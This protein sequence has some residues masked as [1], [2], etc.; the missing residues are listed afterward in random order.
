MGRDLAPAAALPH[1]LLAIINI[2][3]ERQPGQLFM[4]SSGASAITPASVLVMSLL[5]QRA[6]VAGLRQSPRLL[7]WLCRCCGS[8]L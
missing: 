5:R 7:Y 8:A 3:P 6:I 2:Q 1:A 4:R